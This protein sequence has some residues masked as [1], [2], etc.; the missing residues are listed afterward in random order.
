MKTLLIFVN[1][2]MYKAIQYNTKKLASQHY[3]HF[4]K[5]GILDPQTGNRL[6]NTSCE[7]I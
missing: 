3:K 7:L 1:G 5:W 6:K 2:Q 4:K